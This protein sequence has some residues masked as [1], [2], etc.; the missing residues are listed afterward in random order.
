[1]ISSS[2]CE[3]DTLGEF[4]F[5]LAYSATKMLIYNFVFSFQYKNSLNNDSG[6]VFPRKDT[7]IKIKDK[8]IKGIQ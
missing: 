3:E 1:M 7:I 2:T 8:I 4:Y 5:F 6:M